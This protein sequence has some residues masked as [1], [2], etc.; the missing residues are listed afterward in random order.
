VQNN[1]QILFGGL[2]IL[3]LAGFFVLAYRFTHKTAG[4][5][6][7]L[8][9]T[10]S[11]IAE[12]GTLKEAEFRQGDFFRDVESTFNQMVRKLSGKKVSDAND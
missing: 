5:L 6:H 12:S 4:A 3:L 2:F 10:M 9:L 11:D 1:T 7:R 8:K